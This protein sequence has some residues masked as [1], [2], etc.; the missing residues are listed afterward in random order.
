[1]VKGYW[2]PDPAGGLPA[3]VPVPSPLSV[4]VSQAGSALAVMTASGTPLVVTLNCC[5]PDAAVNVA[6]PALLTV[7][8]VPTV[9][10]ACVLTEP[11]AFVN[12]AR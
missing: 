1:M 8:A 6:A 12:V 9:S 10:C 11:A 7:G 5:A 3:R 4:K 2:P